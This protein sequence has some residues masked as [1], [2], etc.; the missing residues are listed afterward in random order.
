MRR[1]FLL[2]GGLVC[3]FA[4]SA[5]DGTLSTNTESSTSDAATAAVDASSLHNGQDSIKPDPIMLAPTEASAYIDSLLRRERFWRPTGDSMKQ[6]LERLIDHYQE[7]S[8]A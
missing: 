2:L 4:V 6:S 5:Q 7:L 8:T 3:T 1:F